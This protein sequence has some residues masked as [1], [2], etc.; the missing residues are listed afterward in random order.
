M[1]TYIYIRINVAYVLISFDITRR[2]LK[3][4]YIEEGYGAYNNPQYQRE[5]IHASFTYIYTS[6]SILLL[7]HYICVIHACLRI[8]HCV[9]DMIGVYYFDELVPTDA[10]RLCP[11]CRN[12]ISAT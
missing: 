8:C 10:G 9:C 6:P 2:L 11:K 7:F 4:V 3:Y 12:R 5:Q 1:G